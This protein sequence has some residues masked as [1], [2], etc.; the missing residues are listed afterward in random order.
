MEQVES[1]N[2]VLFRGFCTWHRDTDCGA[3][4]ECAQP[5]T[6][7]LALSA[8]CIVWPK[9]SNF[10]AANSRMILTNP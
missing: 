9:G 5:A 2:S 6:L 4:T 3:L 1:V 7:H 10:T 8:Q